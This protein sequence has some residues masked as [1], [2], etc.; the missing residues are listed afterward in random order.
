MN[1][2]VVFYSLK[3]SACNCSTFYYKNLR[4]QILFDFCYM[5]H[6]GVFYDH[7]RR[8]DTAYGKNMCLMTIVIRFA[9]IA[10]F[11]LNTCVKEKHKNIEKLDKCYKTRENKILRLLR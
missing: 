1:F 6:L 10:Y 2:G 8:V 3:S 9:C 4:F 11:Y 5:S 7:N